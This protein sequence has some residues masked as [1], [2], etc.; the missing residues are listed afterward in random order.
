MQ[1]RSFLKNTI[2]GSAGASGLITSTAAI[3]SVTNKKQSIK[4]WIWVHP[5]STDSVSSLQEKYRLYTSSGITGLLFA[6]IS[7][8]HFTEAKNAGLEAH[9]WNWTMNKN[10]KTLLQAH[11]EWYAVSREGKSCADHPPYVGYYR[12]LCPSKPAVQQYLKEDAERILSLDYVDGIHLDYIRY[13]DIILPL[14]LWKQYQIEQEK[15]LPAYD[16]CYCETCRES[17]KQKSGTDLFTM[18][19]PD[20]SLSWRQFRYDAINQIVNMI[21]ALAKTHHKKLRLLFFL[22]PK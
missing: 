2:L 10:D 11:P 8:M 9:C 7:E 15:E 18:Q 19:F 22:P 21:A 14:N 6:G 4:N 20:A 13:C 5:R 16:F 12:W 1:R 17:F 3:A